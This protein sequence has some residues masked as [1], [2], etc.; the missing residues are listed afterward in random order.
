MYTLLLYLAEDLRLVCARLY[1]SKCGHTNFCA[2]WCCKTLRDYCVCC[3]FKFI[4]Q[5]S[6]ESKYI[7]AIETGMVMG[8]KDNICLFKKGFRSINRSSNLKF[9]DRFS[10]LIR[11]L[12]NLPKSEIFAYF[13]KILATKWSISNDIPVSIAL[14]VYAKVSQIKILQ[15]GS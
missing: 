2:V 10:E 11:N 4:C 9:L 1:P 12:S 5:A 3:W 6:K 8:I 15:C 14:Q 7:K 13:S